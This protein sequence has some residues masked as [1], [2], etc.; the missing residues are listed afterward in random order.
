MDL[1]DFPVEVE[2]D[3]SALLRL[4]PDIANSLAAVCYELCYYNE[5]TKQLVFFGADNEMFADW[6]EG[7]FRDNYRNVWCSIDGVLTY[8]DIAAETDESQTYAAP[9][10]LNGEEYTLLVRYTY[11]SGTYEILGA[12]RGITTSADMPPELLYRL[13]IGD[14]VEPFL[15]V[16]DINTDAD[17]AP[18][19][20]G[21]VTVT[22]DT[23]FRETPLGDGV[24]YYM[25][26]MVDYD[27]RSYLSQVVE[28][29][30]DKGE[31]FFIGES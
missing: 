29:Q 9:V 17:P 23:A 31:I 15:Y 20:S 27:N 7:E 6:D 1:E 12:V 24:Y 18:I 13:H 25:F 10:M 19:L 3:G 28:I 22:E 30:V 21:S 11:D 26:E 5:E 8:M 16:S 14:I 2:D 4:G